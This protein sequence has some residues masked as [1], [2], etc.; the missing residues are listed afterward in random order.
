MTQW[1]TRAKLVALCMFFAATLA[2]ISYQMI[3]VW[4]VQRCE[5]RGDWWDSED[6]Q[7]LTPMPIWRI[8]G[9]MP[10]LHP[11]LAGSPMARP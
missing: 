2:A 7:C 10:P 11:A 6:R 8:T 9:R 1:I 3:F 5:N 4:P